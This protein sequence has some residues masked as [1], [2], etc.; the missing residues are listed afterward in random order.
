MKLNIRIITDFRFQEPF[1][2]SE[3][4]QLPVFIL[5][6]IILFKTNEIQ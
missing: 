4:N 2:L 3:V 5:S 1:A 6:D